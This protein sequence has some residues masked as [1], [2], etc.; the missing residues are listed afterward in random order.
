MLAAETGRLDRWVTVDEAVTHTPAIA[1]PDSILMGLQPGDRFRLLD[2]V[3]GLLLCSGNDAALALAHDVSGDLATF[4][5]ELTALERRLGLAQTS[6]AGPHGLGAD[7]YRAW[8]GPGSGRQASLVH[9]LRD[10]DGLAEVA[11]WPR[12]PVAPPSLL[13]AGPR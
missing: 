10:P 1:D 12:G 2:L 5:A 11:P 9:A 6:F 7:A 8:S 13:G 3:Y 4:V